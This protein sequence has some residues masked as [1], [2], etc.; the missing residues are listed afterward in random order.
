MIVRVTLADL[1][2]SVID[3]AV[4]VTVLPVGTTDGAVYADGKIVPPPAVDTAG[5]N[6]PQ[7]L[8]P[9]VAV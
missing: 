5:L 4:I 6:D 8:D 9:Q 7:T 3:E 1:L 2:V